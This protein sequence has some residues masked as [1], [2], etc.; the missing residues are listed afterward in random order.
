M[1]TDLANAVGCSTK[2]F[3]LLQKVEGER[4]LPE[5]KGFPLADPALLDGLIS[6]ALSVISN[7]TAKGCN[8]F[9]EP[10]FYIRSKTRL[11]PASD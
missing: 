10:G 6:R 2:S 1:H 7:T 11:R 9:Q 3:H 8:S 5:H 4:G